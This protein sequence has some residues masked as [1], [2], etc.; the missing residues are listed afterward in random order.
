MTVKATWFTE[1]VDAEVAGPDV[2]HV[3]RLVDLL[4]PDELNVK[5]AALMQ[6][7]GELF[8]AGIT[9]PIKD[10]DA[11]SCCACPI[12]E[13]DP[14]EPLE[15]LCSLGVQQDKVITALLVH[16]HAPGR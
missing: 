9:C 3:G 16:R 12:R 15:P 6:D 8:N 10:H 1:A 11:A 5:L 13:T 2:T 4:G 14:L 7:E